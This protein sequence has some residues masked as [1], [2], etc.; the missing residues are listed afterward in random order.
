MPLIEIKFNELRNLVGEKLPKTK[1]DLEPLI[2]NIKGEIKSFENDILTLELADGNRP[3]LWTIEGIARELK[4]ILGVERGLK[5]F[6]A[7]QSDLK[8]F[9]SSKLEKI[10]P[11]IA[12]AVI[13]NIKFTSE[14]IEQLM[15]A[16]SK[17]DTGYGRDRAKA[18]VG[19]YNFDLVKFPLKYTTTKPHENAF[20]PLGFENKISPHEILK[21]HP[22][23][24]K[25]GN[26]IK[27][28]EEY[29]IFIDSD[30]KILSLP[31]IINS[32]DLGKVDENTKN[33][34]I[35]VTGTDYETVNH[36]LT[37]F[38]TALAERGGKIFS[39]TV[40]YPYRNLDTTPHLENKTLKFNFE[41]ISKYLGIKLL[42]DELIKF[43]FISPSL[44]ITCISDKETINR[45]ATFMPLEVKKYA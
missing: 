10:R 7:T 40:D 17:I 31:P 36:I 39:V 24:Q 18:S 26:L 8:V 41:D 14:I 38:A 2:F 4:G 30:N 1:E 29:P 12:C 11:F 42:P 34:L 25:Y 16:Q 23:G 37:I 9:V 21:Q 5:E 35:E 15:Q 44:R 20:I 27:S 33:V 22:K 3:D 32:A 6:V 28:L 43:L 13:K 45:W 19:F